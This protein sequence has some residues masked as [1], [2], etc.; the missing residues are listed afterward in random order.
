[1]FNLDD[2]L[3]SGMMEER[4]TELNNFAEISQEHMAYSEVDINL[5]VQKV[6]KAFTDMLGYNDETLRNISFSKL[7]APESVTKFYNGCEYVK[8]SSSSKD[9]SDDN[10]TVESWGTELLLYSIDDKEIYA[11]VIIHPL[12]FQK[13]LSGFILVIHD[14]T[15]QKLLNKLQVKMFSSEKLHNGA[16]DFV[17]TTSAAVLDTI[18][19]KVSVVVKIVVSFIFL[20]LI[21]A[22]SFDIDEIARGSGKF[23]PT[24]KVQNLKNHEG[25]VVSAIYV[26]EGDSIKKGQ[27]L[28]KFSAISY[29]SKLDENRIS[30]ME[31]KAKK[32]RLKAEATSQ[33]MENIVCEDDCDEK[34]LELE[35]IYYITNKKELQKNVSKQEEQINAKQS[36]LVDAKSKFKILETNYDMLEE[37]F[38]AKKALEKRKIVT[39]YELGVLQ[40]DLNDLRSSI[41][42]AEELIVQTKNQIQE[43]KDGIEETKLNFKNNASMQYNE[44]SAE[45]LRLEEVK[46][47]LEDIISRTIIRSPVDGTVKELFAHTI[48]T[49]I[50]ASAELVT[51]VPKNHDMVAQVQIKPEEIAKLHIGQAVKLKVTAFDYSIYGDLEGNIINISPDTITDKETGENFY[52]IDIQTKKNYLNNNE[53]YKIKVG[54]IVNADVLVGKKTIM[55][56]LLKPILKTT[57]RD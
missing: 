46:K 9:E 36:S 29:Q 54:M 11:K 28:M 41:K 31:L 7:I 15:P 44:T 55:S 24:A 43:I 47:N 10:S 3:I 20:F 23:I 14:V 12:F 42:S 13:K 2:E 57:Q 19:Y 1:M 27:I 5:N 39:K 25:G 17:S 35:K 18:S 50:Q 38:N 16:L 4:F 26:S 56:F 37:E 40:R 21:Y 6:S 33:D 53:K 30:L 45:I 32:A 52:L 48:G 34:L 49:S 8:N 22:V 51:I